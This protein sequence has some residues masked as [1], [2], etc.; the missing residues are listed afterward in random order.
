[1]LQ[2]ILTGR[3]KLVT[4]GLVRHATQYHMKLTILCRFSKALC[5]HLSYFWRSCDRA[6]LI[7]SFKFNQQ[8]A[9][10]YNILY[11]CQCSTCFGRFLRPSS[12]AQELYTAS[13]TCHASLLLPLTVAARKTNT[14]TM[15]DH[16]NVNLGLKFILLNE[17]RI[18]GSERL[19]RYRRDM[20]RFL[21]WYKLIRPTSFHFKDTF[22]RSF[23][24][25][26]GV[27]FCS[28]VLG[29]KCAKS[30]IFGDTEYSAG[31]VAHFI[32][33]ALQCIISLCWFLC[34]RQL[35]L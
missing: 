28:H 8:D 25:H 2:L 6:W 29:P 7:Y 20:V 22:S 17:K 18:L 27:S 34:E 31:S 32:V 24:V 21:Y 1:M 10:L 12:G 13:G 4:E 11:Y 19:I 23:R 33:G 14:L 35:P 15:H 16:V 5:Q 9:T 30:R 26:S 3:C